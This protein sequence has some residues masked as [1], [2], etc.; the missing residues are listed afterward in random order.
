MT[1]TT[2]SLT[3]SSQM[4]NLT[5]PK[6][7]MV[8]AA[9]F[10]KRLRPLTETTPKPM[11]RVLG[12][13]MIDVVLDRLEAV[14]VERAVVN[15]HHLGHV[16]RDHLKTRKSLEIIFSEEEEILETGGGIVK[17]LPL[18]G[19]EPFFTVNAKIIWLNGKTDALLRMAQQWDPAKM[20]ALLLL[21]P[22]VTAVGY[23]GQGDF[24]MDQ[25]GRIRRRPGWQVAPFLYAGIQIC[26]PR[27]FRDPPAGAFSTN[28]VWDRAIEE[29]RLYGLRHDGEWYHVSTPAQLE[30]VERH[31]GYH[32]IRF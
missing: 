10:G 11:V 31:L 27:L 7:A 30:E 17:A 29:E 23:G 16:I 5:V 26:H 21:Q 3:P 32:G 28:V 14:G 4:S 6:T 9:G 18:L 22:T 12:R 19:D 24:L 1:A 25:T 15:L 8:L 13:P 20:D 2:A